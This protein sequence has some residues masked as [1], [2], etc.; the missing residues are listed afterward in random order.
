MVAVPSGAEESPSSAGQ[1]IPI[2]SGPTHGFAMEE[3]LPNGRILSDEAGVADQSHRDEDGSYE[4]VRHRKEPDPSCGPEVKR[5]NLY[6]EQG[7]TVQIP[8]LA[9]RGGGTRSP[10]W[11]WKGRPQEPGGNIR[12]RWMTIC[13]LEEPGT[14][15]SQAPW[16]ITELGL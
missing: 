13:E 7:Q 9:Y 4:G 12:T 16:F 3:C 8:F 15:R 10:V 6:A 11:S 1:R 2:T 14:S 5:G